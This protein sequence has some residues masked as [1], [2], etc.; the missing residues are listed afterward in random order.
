MTQHGIPTLSLEKAG[1]SQYRNGAVPSGTCLFSAFSKT[2]QAKDTTAGTAAP[3]RIPG[4]KRLHPLIRVL[5]RTVVTVLVAAFVLTQVIALH[6]ATGN[7]MYA[8]VKDGDL[9]FFSRLGT[10]TIGDIVLYRADGSLHIGRVVAYGGQEISFPEEGGYEINGYQPAEDIPYKTYRAEG[11]RQAY[12]LVIPEQAFYIL[13][14]YRSDTS[15]SR[16]YGP[17]DGEQ[18]QGKLSFLFR[19]RGF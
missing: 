7:S 10:P 12:P 9:L 19:R 1:I 13:N 11:S 3:D 5:I 14:D 18:I 4:K 8:S 17:V 16:T 15:D 6:R 2:A